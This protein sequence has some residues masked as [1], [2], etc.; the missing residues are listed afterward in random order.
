MK[1]SEYI[2]KLQEYIDNDGDYELN[3]RLEEFLY[4]KGELERLI[5]I[6]T[7][8]KASLI[9]IND[10]IINKDHNICKYHIYKLYYKR[11]Y[12]NPLDIF[13]KRTRIFKVP[14]TL[15]KY[16]LDN[17]SDSNTLYE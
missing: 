2:K 14:K 8:Y 9:D 4:L 1:A 5:E 3:T 11:I 7:K 12:D 15:L 10:E 17:L 16:W 6:S 13:P